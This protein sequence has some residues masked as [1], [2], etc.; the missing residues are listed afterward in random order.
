MRMCRAGL[1]LGLLLAAGCADADGTV[2]LE[3]SAAA[4]LTDA[5]SAVAA[6][7]E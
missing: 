4:S 7:F 2:Q 3:V 5:F 1:A 6:A